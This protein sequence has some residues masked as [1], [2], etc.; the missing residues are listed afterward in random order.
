[1]SEVFYGPVSDEWRDRGIWFSRAWEELGDRQFVDRAREEAKRFAELRHG[2]SPEVFEMW[3]ADAEPPLIREAPELSAWLFGTENGLWQL[4]DPEKK[5]WR[6]YRANRDLARSSVNVKLCG[7][8]LRAYGA[9]RLGARLEW[10]YPP[11]WLHLQAA[12]EDKDAVRAGDTVYWHVRIVDPAQG[13]APSRAPN[14]NNRADYVPDLGAPRQDIRPE[15]AAPAVAARPR[16]RWYMPLLTPF[17]QKRLTM[18]DDTI[19]MAFQSAIDKERRE[20]KD[21]QALPKPREV[22]RAVAKIREAA[23]NRM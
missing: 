10:I 16:R 4:S 5:A 19:T 15:T 1:M 20:G 2:E 21:H 14:K 7:G 9:P 17:A 3:S 13:S 18:D 23:A 11:A 8:E 22:K 6:L 12:S